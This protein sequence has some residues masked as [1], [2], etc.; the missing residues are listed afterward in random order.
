MVPVPSLRGLRKN[1][2]RGAAKEARSS[3]FSSDFV[4]KYSK[5][6]GK[7]IDEA[8]ERVLLRPSQDGAPT[9]VEDVTNQGVSGIRV[10]STVL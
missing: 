1:G 8:S 7:N 5:I 6:F 3:F 2:E 10:L 4:R 9:K